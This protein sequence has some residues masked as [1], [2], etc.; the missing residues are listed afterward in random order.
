MT[1]ELRRFINRTRDYM[2]RG[3]IKCNKVLTDFD[4]AVQYAVGEL[5][6]LVGDVITAEQIWHF[7]MIV[8]PELAE[9]DAEVVR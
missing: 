7:L 2:K 3:T 8:A 5:Q 4:L 9:D 1:A 6:V